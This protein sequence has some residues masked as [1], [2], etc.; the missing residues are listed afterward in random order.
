MVSKRERQTCGHLPS[1]GEA[2]AFLAP[3]LKMQAQ[4]VR[5]LPVHAESVADPRA[6]EIRGEASAVEARLP[7]AET[8]LHHAR[9]DM[10]LHVAGTVSA[11]RR[12]CP[13]GHETGAS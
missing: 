11:F 1:T 6:V 3:G 10:G 9:L 12:E 5:S 7:P 2:V 8:F 13:A 4:A